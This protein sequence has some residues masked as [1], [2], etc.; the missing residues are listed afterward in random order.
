[1]SAPAEPRE[2]QRLIRRRLF[3]LL[4]RA[5]FIVVSLT[6]LMLVGLLTGL[7][8]LLTRGGGSFAPPEVREL[9][10]YYAGRGNWEGVGVLLAQPESLHG[11]SSPDWRDVTVLDEARL[12]VIDNGQAT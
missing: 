9:E 2:S 12:I 3:W 4:L 6:V 1:M 8:G 10:A 7:V 5:F 11:P